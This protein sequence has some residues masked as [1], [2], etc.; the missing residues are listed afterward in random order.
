LLKANADINIPEDSGITALMRASFHGHDV[1]VQAIAGIT[2]LM[3][4]RRRTPTMNSS[5]RV[6]KIIMDI[7][8]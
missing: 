4:Q 1:N 2:A 6:F 8:L 7:Q 5:W 3:I